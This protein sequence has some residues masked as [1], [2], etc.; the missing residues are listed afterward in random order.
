MV[1]SGIITLT[2]DFGLADDYAG[3][4]HG[5][6]WG[7]NPQARIVDLTHGVQPQNILQG[8]FLLAS[9][10]R[11]FPPG[12]VHLAVV[13]P[14][15]GTAR[16]A[17]AMETAQAFFV[18]PDNGLLGEVWEGL[19][20]AERAAARIVE[21][22]EPRYWLPQVSPTF[23]ARDIFAPVAAHLAARLPLQRLGRP[24]QGIVLLEGRRAAFQ[25]GGTLLGRIVHVDRFGNC[26]SNV[27]EGQLV[28]LSREGGLV[29]DVAG[30]LLEGLARTYADAG[31]GQ[32]QALVGSTGRL[33]IAVRDGNAAAQLGI[34]I[35]DPVRV[36]R[37]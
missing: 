21:L 6:I 30:H 22:T 36:S 9:A 7:I 34:S 13:D 37:A 24:R 17:V 1:R 26:I 2:T 16:P 19:S 12:T 18:A 10:W 31:P 28:A 11:Y 14:G 4:L 33:E 35:G 5:V 3:V 32:A 27:V 20:E 15:V 8:A 25:E 29:V 23:H